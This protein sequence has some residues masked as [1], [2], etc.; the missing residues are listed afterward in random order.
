M[1]KKIARVTYW[2]GVVCLVVAIGW[3]VLNAADFYMPK[4]FVPG[5]SLYY[6]SF[7]KG[8]L[9]FFLTSIATAQYANMKD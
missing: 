3:R 8:A 6:M 1:E 5:Q 4:M 7:F 9:L 2:L